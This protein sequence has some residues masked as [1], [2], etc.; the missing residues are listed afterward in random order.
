MF[1]FR[2]QLHVQ[3]VYIMAN[4]SE[5]PEPEDPPL[6]LKSPGWEHCDM[7]SG[8]AVDQWVELVDL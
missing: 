3:P 4:A 1:I 7:C 6:S 8:A 2:L 5:K